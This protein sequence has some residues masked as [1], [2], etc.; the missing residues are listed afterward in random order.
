ML[1][2]I[3]ADNNAVKYSAFKTLLGRFSKEYP[4]MDISFEIKS[5]KTLWKNFF[6][7]L[8]DPEK[9]S[10]ADIVEIPQEWTAV[11]SKLGMFLELESISDEIKDSDYP[12]FLRNSMKAEDSSRLFSA[13]FYG[14]IRSLH[15]RPDMIKAAKIK[16]N[17]EMLGWD[18][19]ISVC[20]SVSADNRRKN[21]FPLDNFNTS[22]ADA[23]DIL[24]CVLN[25][26][27]EGYFSSD[28]G[29]CEIMKDEVAEGIEDYM[30]LFVRKYLPVFQENFYEAAFIESKLSAMAFSWRKPLKAGRNEMTVV[31]F[32]NLRRKNNPA[33]YYGFAVT[34]ACKETGE[35]SV[36]LKWV[37]NFENSSFFKKRL[38]VFEAKEKDLKK[39]LEKEQKIYGDLFASA[40]CP[41]NFSVYPSFEI[42][43]SSAISDICLEILRGDYSKEN[44]FRRLALIKGEADYLLSVY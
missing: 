20:D 24:P 30:S 6:K 28:F 3:L 7:F 11:F 15:Y 34:C 16:S 5:K 19:F 44:L 18:E 13:P 39:Q 35:A 41:P 38:G 2:W 25:R 29:S 1:I 32:P 12:S 31:P 33:R 42:I 22:G 23:A 21:F 4:D 10:M 9:N 8:R 26:G 40:V 27:G 17:M 43:F 37:L 36:F 14:E